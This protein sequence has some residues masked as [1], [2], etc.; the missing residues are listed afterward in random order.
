MLHRRA[1]AGERWRATIV[2]KRRYVEGSTDEKDYCTG[3]TCSGLLVL[4]CLVLYCIVLQGKKIKSTMITSEGTTVAS[5][6]RFWL[7]E[8]FT[9]RSSVT[10]NTETV[11]IIPW[12][13]DLR[14]VTG[15][16]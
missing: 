4:Y 11:I 8:E 1:S 2:K 9:K 6:V 10:P 7:T 12:P 15:L 16:W 14:S 5:S 13:H 3:P